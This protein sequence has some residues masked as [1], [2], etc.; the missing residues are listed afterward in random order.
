MIN[1][2]VINLQ[3]VSKKRKH[4]NTL[5]FKGYVPVYG[6]D[7]LCTFEFNRNVTCNDISLDKNILKDK[8]LL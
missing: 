1:Y 7:K 6:D 4:P 8:L 5:V 3:E 2:C